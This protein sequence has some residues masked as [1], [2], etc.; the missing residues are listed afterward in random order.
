MAK[1]GP[2]ASETSRPATNPAPMSL[3]PC[4]VA[5]FNAT[6]LRMCALGTRLGNRAWVT[7]ICAARTLPLKKPS[8]TSCHGSMTSVSTKAASSTLCASCSE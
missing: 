2:G 5:K 6:A 3:D 4:I 8:T 7:D 1:A